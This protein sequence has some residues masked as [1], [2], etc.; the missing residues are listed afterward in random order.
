MLNNHLIIYNKYNSD[1]N[2]YTK[3]ILTY[4]NNIFN[5]N[6]NNQTIHY[7]ETNINDSHAIYCLCRIKNY[8]MNKIITKH[9][10]FY[11]TSYDIEEITNMNELYVSVIGGGGSD[12]VFETP[13]IDGPFFWLPCCKVYRCIFAITPNNLIK[14]IFITNNIK[15]SYIL[16]KNQFLA[17]DYNN[18][19]HYI[20]KI[21][22]E[23]TE[24]NNNRVVLK[25]HYILY[26][27]NLP[28]CIVKL[29][30]LLHIYYNST[31]RYLFLKSQS[32]NN[33][34]LS[35]IINTSTMFY[36]SF[37]M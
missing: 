7:Y 11:N 20:E 35:F 34:W 17:F 4:I 24:C 36:S 26:S 5:E 28:K 12:N 30:K 14:T 16:N 32:K 8:I 31:M 27:S 15:T 2:L 10:K 19:V 33:K 18:N 21:Q 22:N 23:T 25:L 3:Y 37:F 1:I 6:E 9:N 13:H 29:Y